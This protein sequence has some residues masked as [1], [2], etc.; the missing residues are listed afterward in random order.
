V[1]TV[2]LN[3]RDV[4][5]HEDQTILEIARE[6]GVYIPTLCYHQ[7]LSGMSICRVCNVEVKNLQRLQP[8]CVT[9]V[10]VD[11][12]IE[13]NSPRVLQSRKTNIRLILANHADN[14]LVCDA[15]NLCELRKV[16]SEAG[17]A[18]SYFIKSRT[19]RVIDHVHP[20]IQRDLSKCILCRRCVRACRELANQ[21]MWTVAHRGHE[22]LIVVNDDTDFDMTYCQD[23]TICA[24]VCPVGALINTAKK[25]RE[26]ETCLF[27][28]IADGN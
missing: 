19:P 13:T 10:R 24:D 20:N 17:I 22:T 5:A 11:M 9:K 3:G 18:N 27:S 23:C 6:N 1:L 4:E 21:D 25:R 28:N 12:I 15:A 26:K 8:A 14:C 16:A 7:E 2:T